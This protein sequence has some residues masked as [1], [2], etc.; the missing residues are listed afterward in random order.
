[1]RRRRALGLRGRLV[2]ALVL[3]S[4]VTLA[5]AAV[6]LFVELDQRL[7]L[8]ERHDLRTAA[9]EAR[10]GFEGAG[11]AGGTLHHAALR[12]QAFALGLR[13]GAR[14][15]VFDA[16]GRT[17]VDN[18][19]DAPVAPTGVGRALATG[20]TSTAFAT[21]GATVIVPMRIAGA[22]FVLSAHRPLTGTKQ[23]ARSV[24]R[25]SAVAAAAGLLTALALGV[26]IAGA[27]V[28]RLRRLRDAASDLALQGLDAPAPEDP[29]GDEIGQLAVAFAQM[30][31]RLRHE[32]T[33]RRAFVATASHELRTPLA[34]L[35]GMLE[36]IA[37]G[38]AEGSVDGPQAARHIVLA[39]R[40]TGR[41]SRL[42]SDLLDLSRIESGLELRNEPVDLIEVCRA[43][44]SEFDPGDDAAEQRVVV[45]QIGPRPWGAGDPSAV[46]QIVRITVDNALRFAPATTPV[47]VT[48]QL[49][50]PSAIVAVEDAGPGVEPDEREHIF[51]R[52][53]CGRGHEQDGGFGLG[54][55]IGRELAK[56]MRASL[57]L[58]PDHGPGARFVLRLTAAVPAQATA[59]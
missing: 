30:R 24:A 26:A 25:A 27:L 23:T 52:F 58:D 3:T 12:R 42:A 11:G 45:E 32:E 16:A 56:G 49:R 59:R 8:D 21:D 46:A 4:M 40:Q 55:A 20:H 7:R 38:I 50:G 48:A 13:T 15:V 19:P 35:Q 57:E 39:R 47:R 36:L 14:V 6:A 22:G 44:A 5:V 51:G 2:I 33:A 9:V 29:V 28:R 54:L 43:V 17:V 34:A 37:A 18:D 41:L 53:Q 1:V 31:E 10:G